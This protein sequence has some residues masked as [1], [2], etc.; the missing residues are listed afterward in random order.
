MVSALVATRPGT[1]RSGAGLLYER[2]PSQFSRGEKPPVDCRPADPAYNRDDQCK[3]RA[4]RKF[5]D[6]V[7]RYRSKKSLKP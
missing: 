3:V 7:S 1:G 4:L 6:L 2:D 5:E